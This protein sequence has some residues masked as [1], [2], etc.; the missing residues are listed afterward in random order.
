MYVSYLPYS[1]VCPGH[2]GCFLVLAFVNSAAMEVGVYE[3]FW[4][5]FFSV[6]M[7]KSGITL[8]GRFFNY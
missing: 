4:T 1:F 3:S 7:P 8:G 2:L 5:M 6:Y